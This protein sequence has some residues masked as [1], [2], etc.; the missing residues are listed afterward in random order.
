MMIKI[1]KPVTYKELSKNIKIHQ[2]PEESEFFDNSICATLH[3]A[4]CWSRKTFQWSADFLI[5]RFNPKWRFSCEN[6]RHVINGFVETFICFQKLMEILTD[7]I[8]KDKDFYQILY[9]NWPMNPGLFFS[10]SVGHSALEVAIDYST[11]LFL[12]LDSIFFETVCKE[13]T[14]TSWDE[15]WEI[16][17]SLIVTPKLDPMIIK[18]QTAVSNELKRWC[19]EIE[20]ENSSKVICR[21]SRVILVKLEAEYWNVK[22]RWKKSGIITHETNKKELHLTDTKSNLLEALEDDTM[23]GHAICKKADYTYNSHMRQILGVC[24]SNN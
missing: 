3:K 16:I 19:P 8:Y 2:L 6:E 7:L 11:D 5:W 24:P 22:E 23:F 21:D 12:S 4:Y 20:V 15:A 9:E 13:T 17:N 10:D 1:G 14:A 18:W